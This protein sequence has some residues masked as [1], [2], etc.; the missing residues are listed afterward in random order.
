M[1][2]PTVQYI[3][4]STNQIVAKLTIGILVIISCLQVSVAIAAEHIVERAYFEDTSAQMNFGQAQVQQYISYDGILSKGCSTS[5]FWIRLRIQ[6]DALD[7][8]KSVPSDKK[9]ILRIRPTYL[10][11]IQLFDPLQ[12]STSPRLVGDRYAMSQA[13]YPSLNLNFV[14]PQGEQPRDI[15]LRLKTISV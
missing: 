10:D 12:P 2:Q 15:Y 1:K 14:V 3:N 7:Q 6:P 9:L 4:F 11:E 8:S 13:E 5:A